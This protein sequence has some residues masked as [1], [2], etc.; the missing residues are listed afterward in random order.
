[1]HAALEHNIPVT[2]LAQ[3]KL[4]GKNR[5][6]DNGQPWQGLEATQL[7]ITLMEV[8]HPVSLLLAPFMWNIMSLSAW[9][10]RQNEGER[11]ATRCQ[12]VQRNED[13]IR[14][15]DPSPAFWKGVIC[16]N[17]IVFWWPIIW[18]LFSPPADLPLPAL[19]QI[20]LWAPASRCFSTIYYSDI[21]ESTVFICNVFRAIMIIFSI[22][23]YKE[24]ITFT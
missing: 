1:M 22:S 23:F 6:G 8:L 17:L 13:S 16:F 21:F 24:K 7:L 19:R 18:L 12:M 9:P 14:L 20:G 2:A 3:F 15:T 10:L 4:G 5:Q 11:G